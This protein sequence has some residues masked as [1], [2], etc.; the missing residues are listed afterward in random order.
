MAITSTVSRPR[1]LPSMTA[2]TPLTRTASARGLRDELRDWQTLATSSG[3][4]SPPATTAERS[5]GPISILH[6]NAPAMPA[7]H[8][9]ARAWVFGRAQRGAEPPAEARTRRHGATASGRCKCVSVPGLRSATEGLGGAA[10]PVAIVFGAHHGPRAWMR[11]HGRRDR[12]EHLASPPRWGLDDPSNY[13][14]QTAMSGS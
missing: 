2:G 4:G 10:T 14:C 8:V 3:G 11:L 13:P 9:P 1:G 5:C 7:T 6:T 12:L